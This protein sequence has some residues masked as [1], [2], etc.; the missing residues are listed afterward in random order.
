MLTQGPNPRP[1]NATTGA[2][3]NPSQGQQNRIIIIIVLLH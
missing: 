3:T 1:S 2:T